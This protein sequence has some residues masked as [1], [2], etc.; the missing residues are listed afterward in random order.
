[1]EL[2]TKILAVD[3]AE[4]TLDSVVGLLRSAGYTVTGAGTFE[5]ARRLLKTN[6]YD[7]LITTL[8]LLPYNGLHL[9]IHNQA[10]H[11]ET[12]AIVLADPPDLG[13]D[14]EIRR[15]G[16]HCLKTPVDP[17]RLLAQVRTVLDG[18]ASQ[19]ERRCK[20]EIGC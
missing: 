17:D 4:Y 3:C 10:L 15:L 18:R 5:A 19:V 9:V 16:A 8:R 2:K 11:P 20:S 13:Q 12:K 14:V 1:M 6:R 7:L